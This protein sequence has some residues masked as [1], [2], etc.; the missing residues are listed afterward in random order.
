MTNFSQILLSSVR[1]FL[2]KP[3]PSLLASWLMSLAALLSLGASGAVW[4][5][6]PF[7]E[8]IPSL[9]P[10]NARFVSFGGS[11]NSVNF[12]EQDVLAFG[13]SV[14]TEEGVFVASGDAGPPDSTPEGTPVSMDP[15][16]S[17]APSA[18][19]GYFQHIGHS[20]WLW[21]F[22]FTYDYL[23][24][25]STFRQPVFPQVG[26]FTEG[27][28]DPVP[29]TGNAVA[30]STQTEVA[31]QLA[32]RP[33]VGQS[34]ER[35]FV[36]FGGG[37]LVSHEQTKINQL[38]GFADINGNRG[39]ISGAPQDFSDSGWVWGGSAEVGITYFLNHSW[40]VDC[41]YVLGI[42]GNHAFDFSS[43]FSSTFTDAD[44]DELTQAGTLVGSSTWHAITQ[45][46]GFR[47]G[48]AF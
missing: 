32:F 26:T 25:K 17:F 33:F 39:D 29:F 24:T 3:T 28:D 4:A 6:D 8:E 11:F 13:T 1:S 14:L 48:K 38:V 10:D 9:V 16:V 19:F 2:R 44:G 12:G 41:S 5:E 47:I 34:F 35:A 15:Q 20:N 7:F 46:I 21:G 23:G 18:Q 45:G 37:P 27:T 43:T 36:Y 31:H 42:T 40:F 22:K 30:F